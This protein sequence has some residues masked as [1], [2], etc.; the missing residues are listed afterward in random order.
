MK[1]W[2]LQKCKLLQNLK[3]KAS[4][5]QS[6][7]F[8]SHFLTLELLNNSS[9]DLKTFDGQQWFSKWEKDKNIQKFWKHLQIFAKPC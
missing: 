8:K 4:R 3:E 1:N 2:Y 5:F 9:Q 6:E 7:N